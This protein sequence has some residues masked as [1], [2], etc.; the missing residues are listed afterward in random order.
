MTRMEVRERRAGGATVLELDGRLV[1]GDGADRLRD[2]ID[3]LIQRGQT[4][5]IL[6]LHGVTYIDSSGI[7]AITAK[8][9][10]LRRRGGDLKLVRLSGRCRRVLGITGLLAVF[11]PFDSED[12][13]V[14]SFRVEHS[15]VA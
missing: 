8:Y 10:S 6:D 9:L 11:K 4:E 3:S 14:R 12:A 2:R 1:I 13:A 7:G 5:V 15:I